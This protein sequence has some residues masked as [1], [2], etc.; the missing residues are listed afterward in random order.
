MGGAQILLTI[1]VIGSFFIWLWFMGSCVKEGMWNNAITLLDAVMALFITIPLWVAGSLLAASMIQPGPN[2][3]YLMFAVVMGMGWAFYL[4]SF[5]II[6][7]ITDR[8]SQTKV[9][10]HPL[11][12][13]IGSVLFAWSLSSPLGILSYPMLAL[14]ML[15]R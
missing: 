15:S 10:F 1:H 2:D 5:V 7:A 11:A 14:V 3:L 6:H 4:I 13:K 8:L 9:T 12:D